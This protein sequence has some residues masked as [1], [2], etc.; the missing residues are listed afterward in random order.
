METIGNRAFI[1]K[2]RVTITEPIS[3]TMRIE[4]F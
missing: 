2:K 3:D 4:K 1:V